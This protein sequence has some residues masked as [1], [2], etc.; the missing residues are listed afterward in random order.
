MTFRENVLMRKMVAIV[1]KI[2]GKKLIY[3]EYEYNYTLKTIRNF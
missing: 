1:K 2:P 3:T